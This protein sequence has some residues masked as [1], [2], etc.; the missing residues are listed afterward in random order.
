MDQ[1]EQNFRDDTKGLKSETET[2]SKLGTD[3][4]IQGGRM[5]KK[6]G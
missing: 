3:S 4:R 2:G 5:R 1:R 6:K